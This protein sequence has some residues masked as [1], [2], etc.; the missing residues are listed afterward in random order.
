MRI[1]NAAAASNAAG[2]RL[3][4][5]TSTGYRRAG[6]IPMACRAA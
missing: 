2:S 3:A 4:L 1:P 6:R 5:V